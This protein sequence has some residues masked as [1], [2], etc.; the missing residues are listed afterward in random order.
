M[1]KIFCMAMVVMGAAMLGTLFIMMAYMLPTDIMYAKVKADFDKH[2]HAAILEMFTWTRTGASTRLD[3]YTDTIMLSKA[4]YPH[5]G[6]IES[7][8]LNPSWRRQPDEM[9]WTCLERNVKDYGSEDVPDTY[10][11]Y[12]HGYLIVLKPL[13]MVARPADIKLVIAYLEIILCMLVV[14]YLSARLGLRYVFAFIGTVLFWNPVSLAMAF[15]Y[16]SVYIITLMAMLLILKSSCEMLYRRGIW[17]VLLTGILTSFF[18]FLTYPIVTLGVPMV[19]YVLLMLKEGNLGAVDCCKQVIIL[20]C[21]WVFGYLGMWGCKWVIATLLTDQNVIVNAFQNAAYRMGSSTSPR[22]GSEIFSFLD[23]FRR[24]FRDAVD[25]PIRWL[26]GLV[27]CYMLYWLFAHRTEIKYYA[28]KICP[29][30]V[31]VVIPLIWY[32][33]VS[34]H[35]WVHSWMTFRDLGV[36]VFAILC[37]WGYLD[38]AVSKRGH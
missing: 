7:A 26:Y 3:P 19:L 24:N 15:Q 33:L 32:A 16:A 4:I 10:A 35:S 12:W 18:D 14:H 1:K 22:E 25:G 8:L 23:V 36:T 38:E 17:I 34:N 13:L 11:R 5:Q 20:S 30:L 2:E 29:L 37:A 28:K 21:A 9:P 6:V 31:C 27:F